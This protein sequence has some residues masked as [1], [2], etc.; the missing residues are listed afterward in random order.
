MDATKV[1]PEPPDNLPDGLSELM[2]LDPSVG[3]SV[4]D[5]SG[6]VRY[7]NGRAAELFL[8]AQPEDVVG[9]SLRDLFGKDWAEERMEILEQ[10]KETDKPAIVRH[11]R[12]G[13]QIQSTIYLASENDDAEA[14]FVVL[15]VE[16]EQDPKDPEQFRIIESKYAHFGPLDPLTKREVEVLALVGYG[17]STQ[18]IADA[19]HRSPRTIENHCDALRQKLSS[20]NRVQLAEF[21]RKA[22]LRIEDAELKRL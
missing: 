4:V 3:F 13:R 7:T 11:I 10:V 1:Y 21:A 5:E 9:K 14:V 12:H 20:A 16:G 6:T 8:K 18:Q 19:L 15:T 2:K 17:M 22:N